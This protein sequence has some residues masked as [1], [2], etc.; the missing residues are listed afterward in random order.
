MNLILGQEFGSK[1]AAQDLVDKASHHNCFEIT[2]VKSTTTIYLVK[3][4]QLQVI[5]TSYK[6]S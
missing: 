6:A 4:R 2:T 5:F 3:Y 1:Q